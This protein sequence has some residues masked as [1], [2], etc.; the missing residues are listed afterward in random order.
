[1]APTEAGVSAHGKGEGGLPRWPEAPR[2]A[3][4][5]TGPSRVRGD[6]KSQWNGRAGLR[7]RE[8][9]PV[10][11]ESWATGDP[12]GGDLGL[13]GEA[14]PEVLGKPSSCSGCEMQVVAVTAQSCGPGP[15]T[16][17]ERIPPSVEPAG[18][19]QVSR[20]DFPPG[21]VARGCSRDEAL[22]PAPSSEDH[23]QPPRSRPGGHHAL[24]SR[25][26]PCVS[27]EGADGG[28]S[29]LS[30]RFPGDLLNQGE[31]QRAQ[32]PLHTQTTLCLTPKLPVP[33][34]RTTGV[35]DLVRGFVVRVLSSVK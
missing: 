17:E 4:N 27:Q 11:S 1:M 5:G 19:R 23:L 33:H 31:A 15:E 30:P 24:P 35:Y 20:V 29:S 34:P 10:G 9:Q 32:R 21:A 8:V 12:H 13:Q 26:P 7:G 28:L 25:T 14:L 6:Q 2:E 18:A 22:P 3:D 16:P